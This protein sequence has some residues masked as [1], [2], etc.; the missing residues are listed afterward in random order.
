MNS[1]PKLKQSVALS[2]EH[3]TEASRAGNGNVSRGLAI[4]IDEALAQR[5]ATSTPKAAMTCKNCA[6]FKPRTP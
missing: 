6:N 1:I 3:L 5:T 2:V 4:L